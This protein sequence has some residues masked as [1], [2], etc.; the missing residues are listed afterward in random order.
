MDLD[1]PDKSK[2]T[3][4]FEP[5]RWSVV[6]A[7][8]QT[9]APGARDALAELCKTYWRPLYFFTRRRGYDHHRAEDIV[10]S[11]F[12]GL[13]ESKTLARA[14]PLKGKFRNYLLTALQNYMASDHIRNNTLKRGGGQLVSIE[15]ADLES[16]FFAAQT[17]P[18]LPPETAFEREWA[19][20]AV[21]AALSRL[22]E[23]FKRRG[24]KDIFD[25]LQ[26]FLSSDQPPG[27]YE[28]TA[29]RL[30]LSHGALRTGI[31][32]LRADFR[33]QLRREVARTIDTPDQIEE[34]M[35]YLRTIL[36]NSDR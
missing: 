1:T 6:L 29:I 19:M 25:A 36:A 7:S 27:T 22:K 12:L 35:R 33:T 16:K 4:W 18:P 8:A 34:E 11:F 13:I 21:E 3:A 31:H 17:S 15:D 2:K 30:G 32:R 23:D 5:T 9:Q 10:Q 20:S 26:P 14:D 24:K 28:D